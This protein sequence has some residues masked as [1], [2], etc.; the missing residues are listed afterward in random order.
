MEIWMTLGNQEIEWGKIYLWLQP[1][2]TAMQDLMAH[3]VMT[4]FINNGVPKMAM[5]ST[6]HCDHLIKAQ[7]RGERDL[8]QAKDI[9][10]ECINSWQLQVPSMAWASGGL[11]L[12]SFTLSFLVACGA[13][14]LE[15][16]VLKL[17]M[18]C[19]GF[20]RRDWCEADV[21]AL[22]L[23]LTHRCDPEG[24]RHPCRKRQHGCY[25][26]YHGPGHHPNMMTICNMSTE[27]GVLSVLLQAQNEEISDQLIEI[28]F[29]KLKPHVNEPSILNW[30]SLVQKW[31]LWQRRK[32]GFW[33]SKRSDQQLHQLK[34]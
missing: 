19:L 34:L 22:R 21:P 8:C 7:L 20:P 30:P 6:I 29:S 25:L 27:I 3:M 18:A 4:Q 13:S 17:W 33:T 24:G 9:N 32:N 28:N 5:P 2:Y 15:L 26:E 11:D 16:K 31:I 1:N 10:H 23:D 12:E 14:A